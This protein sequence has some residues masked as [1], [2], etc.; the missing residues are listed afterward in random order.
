MSIQK[1]LKIGNSL[2]ITLPARL[3]KNLSLRPGDRVEVAQDLNNA[4]TL[5]FLDNHQ[6]SLD[7]TSSKN[8]PKKHL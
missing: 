1:I 3:V 6:L 4:L 5:V 2:G 7:L 8:L